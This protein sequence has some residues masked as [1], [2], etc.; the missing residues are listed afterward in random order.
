[1]PHLTAMGTALTRRF[2]WG[3]TVLEDGV[4]QRLATEAPAEGCRLV[5]TDC[6]AC[7]W[8]SPW[9]ARVPEPLCSNQASWLSGDRVP[10]TPGELGVHWTVDS[11]GL[12]TARVRSLRTEQGLVLQGDQPVAL[13]RDVEIH[14][15]NSALALVGP[16]SQTLLNALGATL[17]RA[18]T[19]RSVTLGNQAYLAAS[20]RGFAMPVVLLYTEPGL[21]D[22]L[23]ETLDDS[24]VRF[25]GWEVRRAAEVMSGVLRFGWEIP[26]FS[27]AHDGRRGGA[28][29]LGLEAP[30]ALDA[31]VPSLWELDA[32]A[33]EAVFGP[34]DPC[35]WFGLPRRASG[36]VWDSDGRGVV[37]RVDTVFWAGPGRGFQALGQARADHRGMSVRVG[38]RP[39][40]DERQVPA[41]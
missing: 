10:D 12:V 35:A 37:G 6:V 9:E 38:V 26:A 39:D 34:R 13:A 28:A 36:H 5:W 4:L 15:P 17:P 33:L 1:M 25:G 29:A 24:G 2:G 3:P 14:A 30:S 8:A 18:G 27:D 21:E 7:E 23:V 41:Q 16:G 40:L 20:L 31:W 22:G 11:T 19:V 32:A